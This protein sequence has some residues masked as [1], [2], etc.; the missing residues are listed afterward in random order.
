M[1]VIKQTIFGKKY[2]LLVAKNKNQK[3]KGMNIFFSSPK[4]TGMLFPYRNEE[5]NRAFVMTKTPFDLRIIFL[6]RY[7]NI[8]YQA[9]GKKYQKK[10]IICKNPSMTVIEIPV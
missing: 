6:D 5:P 9:I 2:R 3:K 10:P 8:V 7:N 1:Q 4:N